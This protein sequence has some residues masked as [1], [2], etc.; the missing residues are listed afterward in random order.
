MKAFDLISR[1]IPSLQSSNTGATALRIMSELHV[2][3]LPVVN[4]NL[5]IGL[6]SEED[7]LNNHGVEE[8]IGNLPL[9]L[10]RPFIKDHQHL[11]EVLK[12]M[13]EFN[14]TLIPVLDREE[15]FIGI[16]SR[17]DV[18]GFFAS[19]TDILEPG[20]II[21]LEVNVKDYS[22]SDIARIIEQHHAKV[23]CTFAKTREDSNK[24]ELTIKLNQTDVQPVIA[25]LN[26]YD[27]LVKETF[28]EPEYFENMKERYDALMNYLNI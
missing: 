26:R 27:Y 6:I 8:A 4:E 24:M 20:G 22:L 25:S 23:L 19:E 16:I 2:R 28:T 13:T 17:E 21:V 10:V 12:M 18:L 7:I 1:N 9:S 14:L 5:L 11:F 15:N 3:H